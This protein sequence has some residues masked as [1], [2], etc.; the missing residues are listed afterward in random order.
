MATEEVALLRW[1]L[2]LEMKVNLKVAVFL[3]CS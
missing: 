1:C 3:V 2:L